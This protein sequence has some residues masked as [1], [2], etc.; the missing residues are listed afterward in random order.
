MQVDQDQVL[1]QYH[2]QSQAS[3]DQGGPQKF[4]ALKLG[5]PAS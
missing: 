4:P 1:Q 3:R 5:R 2:H